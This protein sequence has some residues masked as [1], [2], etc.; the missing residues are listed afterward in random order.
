MSSSLVN[1]PLDTST[2]R[3]TPCVIICPCDKWLPQQCPPHFLLKATMC[4]PCALTSSSRL[5]YHV[6]GLWR[7]IMWPVMWLP[8]HVPSSLSFQ[9]NKIKKKRSKISKIKENKIKIVSIQMS[10]TSDIWS[11]RYSFPLQYTCQTDLA[12]S[13]QSETRSHSQVYLTQAT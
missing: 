9:E 2:K 6:L 4:T 13:L 1:S 3:F 10:M 8:C 5:F 11:S 7:H 12:Y